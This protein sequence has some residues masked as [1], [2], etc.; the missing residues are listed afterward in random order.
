MPPPVMLIAACTDSLAALP[1]LADRPT[2]RVLG[3]IVS[4]IILLPYYI[5]ACHK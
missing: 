3:V 1:F 5:I 4:I 2:K